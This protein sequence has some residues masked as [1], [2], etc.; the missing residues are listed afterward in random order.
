MFVH[1]GKLDHVLPPS[2]Y[3]SESSFLFERQNLFLKHWHIVGLAESVREKGGYVASEVMGIPVVVHHGDQ[4]VVA[5]RNTCAHRHAMLCPNGS[6]HQL[7]LTCQ[8]HGWQYSGEGRVCKVPD[9]PS[10]KGIKAEQLRL[11]GVKVEVCGPFVLVCFDP[12]VKSFRDHLGDFAAEFDA[13]FGQHRPFG[14]WQT[15]HAVNWKIVVENAVESYHVPLVHPTT[16]RNYKPSEQHD[17]QLASTNSRYADLQPW[18]NSV[19]SRGFRFLAKALLKSPNY[20][21]FKHTHVYPNHLL[22]YGDLMSTWTV[23]EP[24]DAG[25]CRYTLYS[26]VP[27]EIRMGAAGRILQNV[28]SSVLMRQ[29]KKI[30]GEDMDLWPKVHGGLRASRHTGVLSCREERIWAFQQYLSSYGLIDSLRLIDK[31]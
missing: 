18:D 8:Y 3:V 1:H 11:D 12:A 21:R 6:G 24:L 16:F 17:H 29:L 19:V 26:F 13:A 15:E 5:Y 2:A 9:G 22:Y 23:V 4:G 27:A 14:T 10:F 31:S 7:Q 20:E 28:S 25:R 30:L